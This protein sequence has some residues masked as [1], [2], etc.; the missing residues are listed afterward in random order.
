MRVVIVPGNGCTNIMQSNWYG[1][2]KHSLDERGV[3]CVAQNMPDPYKAR[4]EIWIKFMES[5][6]NIDD[7]TIIVGHSSGAQ[8]ALRYAEDHKVGGVVL[9]AAT[10]TDLG[11]AGERASGY[12]PLNNESENLYNFAAM[13]AN[14]P[15]WFQFHSDDDC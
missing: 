2:L 7:Q 8:A 14:C 5:T 11:D 6:L 13:R 3:D 15:R 9:V 12:Y 1:W 4:R 10:F